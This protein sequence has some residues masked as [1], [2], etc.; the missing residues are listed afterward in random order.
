MFTFAHLLIFEILMDPN[1]S[2]LQVIKLTNESTTAYTLSTK[3]TFDTMQDLSSDFGLAASLPNLH[4]TQRCQQM[5]VAPRKP[6]T[7]R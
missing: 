4:V 1:G 6:T 3:Y 7:T 5:S 2:P